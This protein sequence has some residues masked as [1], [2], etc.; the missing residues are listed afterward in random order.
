[1]EFY[2]SFVCSGVTIWG[3]GRGPWGNPMFGAL[4]AEWSRILLFAGTAFLYFCGRG[5]WYGGRHENR[6]LWVGIGGLL[7]L[8]ACEAI[9]ATTLSLG[10][11]S[12]PQGLEFGL[13]LDSPMLDAIWAGTQAAFV[14][15]PLLLSLV[16]L[17]WVMRPDGRLRRTS[18]APWLYCAATY[19]FA[20]IPM[21]ASES[22]LVVGEFGY[23]L[24]PALGITLAHLA[25][26]ATYGSL[27]L[28]TGVALLYGSRFARSGALFTG[29]VNA[30][31]VGASWFVISW[32]VSNSVTA[33]LNS[34]P[35]ATPVER[36][37]SWTNHDFMWL[38][39]FPA[40]YV[41]PW[42]LIAI[43]AWRVP[44]RKPPDDDTP[45][46]RRY[47][48][49]CHYNLYGNESGRCPECGSL[50]SVT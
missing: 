39:V 23:A 3:E 44:M 4:G 1:M 50:L 38:C 33:L 42:L 14:H 32:L 24:T 5:L 11:Y 48:A 16:A 45:F 43:Y 28:A 10:R 13:S 7:F 40:H 25:I 12:P 36:P 6:W 27:I 2:V 18:K 17:Y 8:T 21:I 41:L 49:K 22:N 37:Y 35:F 29:T 15:I 34:V 9:A 26:G 19:C 20:C 31:A 30:V 46:P 47:C